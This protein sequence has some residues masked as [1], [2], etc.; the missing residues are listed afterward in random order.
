[1]ALAGTGQAE[2]E[3][4]AVLAVGV[5][6]AQGLMAAVAAADMAQLLAVALT[7]VIASFGLKHPIA[8]LPGLVV[9]VVVPPA[10]QLAPN[11]GTAACM[12][13]VAAE[14]Y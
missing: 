2:V 9:A 8:R 12:A 10:L 6:L 1:M 7:V 3:V 4:V 11:L 14:Q 13:L 5:A